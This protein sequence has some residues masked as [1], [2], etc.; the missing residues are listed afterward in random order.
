M[1]RRAVSGCVGHRR[2]FAQDADD[3]RCEAVR[4]GRSGR[5][6]DHLEPD[7]HGASILAIESAEF[8]LLDIVHVLPKYAPGTSITEFHGVP[9][10]GAIAARRIADCLDDQPAGVSVDLV[11][12]GASLGI[13]TGTGRHTQINRTLGRLV[14]FRLARI[15]GEVL[16]VHTSF[17]P[18]PCG[19]RRRLPPELLDA[20]TEHERNCL[21]HI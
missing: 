11:E 16:E 4:Q 5:W 17:P 8:V 3:S 12:F 7:W 2:R 13:G 15:S 18:V 6:R 10:K 21:D 14:D 19:L 1:T 20:L 9:P